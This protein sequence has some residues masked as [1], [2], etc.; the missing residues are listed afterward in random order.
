MLFL[1]GDGLNRS[2]LFILDTFLYAS[3]NKL[4]GYFLCFS[5]CSMFLASSSNCLSSEQILLLLIS[6]P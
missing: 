6:S 1:G 5:C 2:Y 3:S 4:G